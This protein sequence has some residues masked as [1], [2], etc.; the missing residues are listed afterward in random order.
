MKEIRRLQPAP[1]P[2]AAMERE[3]ASRP[4]SSPQN[5]PGSYWR[6]SSGSSSAVT[7][8]IPRWGPTR[9]HGTGSPVDADQANADQD[10]RGRQQHAHG[11]RLMQDGPSQEDGDDWIDIGV[12]AGLGDGGNSQEPDVSGKPHQRAEYHQVPPRER[13]SQSHPAGLEGMKLPGDARRQ[14]QEQPAADH[15]HAGGQKWRLG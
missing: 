6:R 9:E 13:G 1:W 10:N 7:R 11:D 3:K 5:R 14:Q 4:K 12:G 2:A 15:L 8:A